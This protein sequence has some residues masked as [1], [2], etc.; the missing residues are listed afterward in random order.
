MYVKLH[1]GSS[2]ILAVCDEDLVGKSFEEGDLYLDVNEEFYK[3]EKKT[4]D[5]VLELLKSNEFQS[6]NIVGKESISVAVE[7]GLVSNKNVLTVEGVPHA[8][9]ILL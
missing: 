3:G 6:F 7:A 4:K 9:S 2:K 8:Q 5:E 1:E